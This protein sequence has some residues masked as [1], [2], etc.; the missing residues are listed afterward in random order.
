MEVMLG[1]GIRD[2]SDITINHMTCNMLAHNKILATSYCSYKLEISSELVEAYKVRGID[3][4]S[5][6]IMKVALFSDC[7]IRGY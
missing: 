5:F 1:S 2:C 6:N 4:Y 3:A 7:F